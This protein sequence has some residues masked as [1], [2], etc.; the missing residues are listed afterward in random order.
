MD[1]NS[2]RLYVLNEL[3]EY[4]FLFFSYT[5]GCSLFDGFTYYIG[6]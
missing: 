2:I 6:C 3:N 5:F 4:Y 1:N